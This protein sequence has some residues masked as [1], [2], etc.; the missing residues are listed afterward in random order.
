MIFDQPI[1]P[2]KYTRLA[3]NEMQDK[4]NPPGPFI[5]LADF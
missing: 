3:F 1:K 4:K 5:G 2:A